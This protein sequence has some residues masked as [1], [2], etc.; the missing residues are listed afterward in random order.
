LKKELAKAI[1]T[2]FATVL[3]N[4]IRG[5]ILAKICEPSMLA[6]ISLVQQIVLFTC[7]LIG[8]FPEITIQNLWNRSNFNRERFNVSFGAFLGGSI[9]LIVLAIFPLFLYFVQGQLSSFHSA[10]SYSFFVW[11]IVAL[12]T[13]GQISNGL[14]ITYRQEHF[15]QKSNLV[16]A[17][18]SAS[19]LAF[20]HFAHVPRSS[21]AL[22]A[23]LFLPGA[24]FSLRKGLARFSGIA[25]KLDFSYLRILESQR[26]LFIGFCLSG[27][28]QIISRDIFIDVLGKNEAGKIN[29]ALYASSSV[30]GVLT[31]LLPLFFIPKYSAMADIERRKLLNLYFSFCTSIMGLAFLGSYFL[32]STIIKFA[33]GSKYLGT[34]VYLLAVILLDYLRGLN[35]ILEAAFNATLKT[36]FFVGS[37]VLIFVSSFV[38][39][40]LFKFNFL[41]VEGYFLS[42]AAA[43]L[44]VVIFNFINE[45]RS[46][47]I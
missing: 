6:E 9:C 21:I 31:A 19:L 30:L 47:K 7:T 1:P 39:L 24:M 18:L 4:I 40:L 22:L 28:Y 27:I 12:F 32:G 34:E 41:S 13:L 46:F 11:A 37:Q 8:A 5:L 26:H 29:F 45:R 14:L 44:V 17:S 33:F 25:F 42:A 2:Q 43:Y 35:W 36:G 16:N 10:G 23:I 20:I 15:V 3:L 38:L